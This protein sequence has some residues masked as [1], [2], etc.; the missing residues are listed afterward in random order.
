[1][2]NISDMTRSRQDFFDIYKNRSAS[3]I[4]VSSNWI[5]QTETA[6]AILTF[7]QNWLALQSTGCY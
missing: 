1:M 3:A 6:K 7:M 5:Y 2:P 4:D